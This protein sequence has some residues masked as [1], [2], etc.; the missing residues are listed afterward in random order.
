MVPTSSA[1]GAAV[2]ALLVANAVASSAAVKAPEVVRPQSMSFHACMA[3]EHLDAGISEEDLTDLLDY[4]DPKGKGQLY[5][6]AFRGHVSEEAP[7]IRI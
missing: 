6:A 3:I 5:R 7:F 1:L 4:L 2:L